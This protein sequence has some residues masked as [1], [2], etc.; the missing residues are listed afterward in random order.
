MSG[1][2]AKFGTTISALV[3]ANNISNPNI[4][5]VGQKIYIGGHSNAYT[6]QSGDNLSSIAAK[7]GTTWQALASKNHIANPN[8]IYVGQTIQ[9]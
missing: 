6:V 1:I 4:I 7:F 8:V 9:I 2:A 5:F 3:S